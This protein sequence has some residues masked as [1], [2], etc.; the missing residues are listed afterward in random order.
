ME[1]TLT[2]PRAPVLV[3]GGMHRSGTSCVAGL[4]Q[5]AGL[6][7]G[8]NLLGADATNPLG[9][10]E[11]I[12]FCAFHRE[13]LR[14]HGLSGDGF[15]A[16]LRLE[17][18]ADRYRRRAAALV[19]AR[20]AL[21]RP[22]GWKDPRTVLFLPLW[23][24]LLPDAHYLFV[25]RPPWDVV[26]SLFRRGDPIFAR[27]PAFA[28]TVWE[29]TNA[30]ILDFARAFPDRV[31]VRELVQVAADPAALCLAVRQKLEVPIDQ[32]QFDIR[33]DLLHSARAER[34]SFIAAASPG[35]M[36]LLQELRALAGS[37]GTAPA[38]WHGGQLPGL[39]EGMEAWQRDP[40]P[41]PAGAA[42]R[43]GI[44]FIGV[45]VYR[46][47]K[48]VA[49][50][51]RSILAQD[52]MEFRVCIS[53]DG[54]DPDCIEECRPFLADSRFELHIQPRRLG[55]AG[56]LNWLMSRCRED[57]FCFWQ[58]D[59]LASTSFL[60]RLVAHAMHNPEAG[61]VFADVQWFGTRID[62]VESPS[63][64]GFA[65]ERVLWQ[66]E[67]GAY[68]PFF[69]LVRADMLSRVGP[70]RLTMH[71]SALEDQ[72]WLARL[73]GQAPWHRVPGA[74]YFKRGHHAETHLDWE[75]MRDYTERRRIWLEWGVGMLEA[76]LAVSPP[77]EHENLCDIVADRLTI[78]SAGR[79][80]FFDA[81]G[82]GVRDMHDLRLEFAAL[83]RSRL[84]MRGSRDRLLAEYVEAARD[85]R[86]LEICTAMG[87]RGLALLGPG[88][89]LPEAGGV[90]SDG[91]TAVLRLPVPPEGS[92]RVILDAR[93]YS[94]ARGNRRITIRAGES[95]VFERSFEPGGDQADEHIEFTLQG[96]RTVVLDMPWAVSPS[97]LGQ[98]PDTRRLG[99]CLHGVKI[100]D[101]CGLP[102]CSSL[103]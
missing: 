26:D 13:A 62:R 65:L 102:A 74:L 88:W 6:F 27:N 72:V 69:G 54:E 18:I 80:F 17:P 31:L 7:V 94:H 8:E 58:Q 97:E 63:L 60:S 2:P 21:M 92:W 91:P 5:S 46:G 15:V 49:E 96:E 86:M 1:V 90:W 67:H 10:F 28:L 25:F 3:I 57:F 78:P 98:A 71:D 53:L 76:A 4:L 23:R 35:S 45:P 41:R 101:A 64:E 30:R 11:D 47:Q 39:E 73:A 37:T 33:A 44:V 100:S 81:V 14:A 34:A 50:T 77:Q 24:E 40:G 93:P 36:A 61:C 89:S 56:N 19:E 99:V 29:D 79:W 103:A 9:H 83:I 22:W 75:G 12:E 85:R 68:V 52:Y 51:L 20:R 70:L 84:G 48:F 59:D 95:I 38:P 43:R 42:P 82:R 66:I 16:K 55:W 87:E 32:P